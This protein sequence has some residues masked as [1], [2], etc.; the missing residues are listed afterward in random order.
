MTGLVVGK[1]EFYPYECSRCKEPMLQ[2]L[3]SRFRSLGNEKREAVRTK[4]KQPQRRDD[5]NAKA[6]NR[7]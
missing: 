3:K 1:H 2:E 7:F 6:D 4:T 5:D